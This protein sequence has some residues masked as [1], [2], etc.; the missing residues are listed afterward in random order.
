MPPFWESQN[1]KHHFSSGPHPGHAS[2]VLEQD[3]GNLVDIPDYL[4]QLCSKPIF[5][6]MAVFPGRSTEISKILCK[7]QSQLAACSFWA[8][9]YHSSW[10]LHAVPKCLRFVGVKHWMF[11]DCLHLHLRHPTCITIEPAQGWSIG[12]WCP[13]LGL[14]PE[15]SGAQLHLAAASGSLTRRATYL[16]LTGVAGHLPSFLLSPMQQ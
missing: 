15:P 12:Q 5:S 8:I 4:Q 6:P 9:P 1:N 7:K 16:G 11:W 13:S 14:E 10:T 2:L 3:Q